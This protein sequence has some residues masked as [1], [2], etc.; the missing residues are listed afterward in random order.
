MEENPRGDS[1]NLEAVPYFLTEDVISSAAEG[2]D[3]FAGMAHHSVQAVKRMDLGASYRAVGFVREVEA[4]DFEALV[5]AAVVLLA[6]DSPFH[7]HHHRPSYPDLR[8]RQ[9]L[10]VH[11]HLHTINCQSHTHFQGQT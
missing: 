4:H 9:G 1:E 3:S 7:R 8:S 6:A 10:C 5:L 2:Y 11:V